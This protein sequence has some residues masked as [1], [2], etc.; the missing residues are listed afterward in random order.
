MVR[1]PPVASDA[2]EPS[3]RVP[4]PRLTKVL[5]VRVLATFSVRVPL[6]LPA[7]V[8]PPV[9]LNGLLMT[10]AVVVGV[11]VTRI[12][13]GVVPRAEVVPTKLAVAPEPA[14]RLTLAN[15]NRLV[16]LVPVPLMEVM[17][18]LPLL[19]VRAPTDSAVTKPTVLLPCK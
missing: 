2:A 1:V 11:A 8:R 17:V 18:E 10:V 9:P 15:V 16:A 14:V 13:L 4:P 6:L 3:T 5:P 12:R 19:N 7:T